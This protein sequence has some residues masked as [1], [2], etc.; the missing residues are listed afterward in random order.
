MWK[1]LQ[2]GV[3]AFVVKAHGLWAA[4]RCFVELLL[5]CLLDFVRR[6]GLGYHLSVVQVVEMV[7]VVGEVAGGGE[8]EA[9]VRM[10]VGLR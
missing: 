8:G 7:F 2:R 5:L 1:E 9:G 6:V 3:V 4:S 10:A